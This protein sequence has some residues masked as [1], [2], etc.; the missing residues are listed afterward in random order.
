MKG[1]VHVL[2]LP[3]NSFNSPPNNNDGD[4]GVGVGV[5]VSATYQ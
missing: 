5:G 2:D 3:T 1:D 4:I